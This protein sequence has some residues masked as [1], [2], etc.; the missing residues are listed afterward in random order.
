MIL[1]AKELSFSYGNQGVLKD[2]NLSLRPGVTAILGPNAAGKSTLLRCLARL[3][4]SSGVILLDGECAHELSLERWNGVVSYLPQNFLSKAAI[5]VFEAVLL[6]R[7][8]Q[9]TIRV[10]DVDLRAVETLL[11]DLELTPLA[12]RPIAA[13]SGGQAQLV[14][15]A[16]ALVR[17]PQILLLDEPTSSLDL[18]RQF[19]VCARV[20]RLSLA[21]KMTT[22]IALHD[23]NL[24][25]R[26]ADVVC[27][28]HQGSIH[29]LGPPE[30][31]LTC[32]MIE[33]V[34]RVR[35]SVQSGTDGRP[36]IA[37]LGPSD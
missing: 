9:L 5:T 4:R 26:Y 22:A 16:Q 36:A 6:G 17:E 3:N 35:A 12:N 31:V 30:E 8:Q 14:S 7:I 10:R 23:L 11:R 2:V 33:S 37:I 27:M 19:N 24:A 21:A 13:L 32:E 28:I 20:R 34:Y 18:R 15:I 1:E 29:G 25:A